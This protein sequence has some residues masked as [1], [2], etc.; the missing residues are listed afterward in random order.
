[1]F[2]YLYLLFQNYH[3]CAISCIATDVSDLSPTMI[4]GEASVNNGFSIP[5]IKMKNIRVNINNIKV[6]I[7][8]FIIEF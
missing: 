8:L 1:M 3:E 2:N 4:E 5:N 6:Q 7:I